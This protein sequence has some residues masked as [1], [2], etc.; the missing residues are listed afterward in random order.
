MSVSIIETAE[1]RLKRFRRTGVLALTEDEI[2]LLDADGQAFARKCQAR[3]KAEDN[4]PGHERVST[5]TREQENRGNHRGEC[6]HCG[7]DMSL[8]SGD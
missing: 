1:D 4:C 5:A 2:L 3:R 8:D 6:K 7:K